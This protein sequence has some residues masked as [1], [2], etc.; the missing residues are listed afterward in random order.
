MVKIL[1]II[2]QFYTASKTDVGIKIVETQAINLLTSIDP[3]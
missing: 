2:C 3:C 1:H